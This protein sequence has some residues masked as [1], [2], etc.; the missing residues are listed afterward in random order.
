M[1]LR[2]KTL[3]S[4]GLTIIGLA[5]ILY[6]ASQIILVR[7]YGQLE[8]QD[9]SNNVDRV[10]SALLAEIAN[11]DS[12][13]YDWAAWDDTYA[14]ILDN[15]TDYIESNLVD[16][17]FIGSELNL[18]VYVNQS[19]QTVFGKAFDLENETEVPV[20]ES[21]LEL[22]SADG[23][24]W[25][26]SDTG[27]SVKGIIGLAEDLM[28]IA[29]R[30]IITSQDEGPIRGALIMGYCFD[31][32]RMNSLSETTHLSLNFRRYIDQQ[33]PS[34]FQVALSSLSEDEQIFVRPLGAGSVSGYTLFED[35]Y[36][37]SVLVLRVDLPR[38]IYNQGQVSIAY[39][40]LF[41]TSSGVVFAIVITLLLEKVVLSR[42]SN[43]SGTVKS[44]R[45]HGDLSKRV[46]IV[47]NDELSSLADEING[48]LTNLEKSQSKLQSMNEKLHVV[49]KLTR[50]DA[51]NKLSTVATNVFLAR[52]ELPADHKALKL[53]DKI[54][55]ACEKVESIFE[56]ARTYERLGVE[57]LTY[58]D[59][60][61]SVNKAIELLPT[62][63]LQ[64]IK[65]ENA[66][67]GLTVLA[68]SILW[69]LFYN[70]IDNSLKHG[71]K[72]G[73]IKVHYEEEGK[74]N[75]RLVYEDDGVGISVGEKER[76]F[77]EGYGKG[78]GY[79]L[80]LIRKMCSV[81]DWTIRETGKPG[82]GAQFT[83]IIP[84][85]TEEGRIGYK[86]SKPSMI[87]MAS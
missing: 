18:I 76:I 19:G 75:L 29:S 82:K 61:T 60:Q 43:L 10:R 2:K 79:G 67:R 22:L 8:E 87:E 14:F 28:I 85:I 52:N 9:T 47:G 72:V 7:S 4:I 27:D 32:D 5:V 6:V 17:T 26:H 56:F 15:D 73:Q 25:Q 12:F 48:M 77:E 24:L 23:L 44:I 80:H 38:S 63:S 45:S 33:M 71:E 62:E 55:S 68:D 11:L 50:H 81:Y 16:E 46:P 66:C 1:N 3:I 49:G 65:M 84:R 21:F 42:L 70:L 64:G 86:L 30:P 40:I 78:S 35:I 41:L 83:V 31:S 53:L 58:I 59:V 57:E 51:Q 13:V 34:D 74:D 37:E 20:P 39:F 36:G 69:R 54:E